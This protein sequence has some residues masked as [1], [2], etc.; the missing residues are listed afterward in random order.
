[1]NDTANS[2]AIKTSPLPAEDHPS[3]GLDRA[4]RRPVLFPLDP[5]HLQTWELR[6]QISR[7]VARD[8]QTGAERR[9]VLGEGPKNDATMRIE[10]GLQD[11]GVLSPIAGLGEEMKRRSVV[12]QIKPAR[13]APLPQVLSEPGHPVG[14]RS[15]ALTANLQ[16]RLS[17]VQHGD[18]P[19][20]A[21]DQSI[22]QARR[23][24][25]YVNNRAADVETRIM[26]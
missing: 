9:S 25:T 6:R 22:C 13:R 3:E 11:G 4:P 18:V 17:D 21:L 12:P 8:R 16:R 10:R 5:H 7:R 14:S 20:T 26:Q 24:A 2:H 1:M 19:H 23:P 15:E